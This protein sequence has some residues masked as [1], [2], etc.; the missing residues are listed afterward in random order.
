M[1]LAATAV[2]HHREPRMAAM[3]VNGRLAT[4]ILATTIFPGEDSGRM[5][6]TD[7]TKAQIQKKA[8]HVTPA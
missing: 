7:G 8:R 3:I 4:K 1:A 6:A 2:H 5:F